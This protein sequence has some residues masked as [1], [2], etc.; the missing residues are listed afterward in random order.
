MLTATPL[1]NRL[2]DLYSLIDLLSVARGHE[3]PFGTEGIFARRFI[4]DDRSRARKLNQ[5]TK[6][7]FRSIVYGYMSRIRRGDANLHFP[8]RVVQLHRVQP[9]QEE[10][11]LIAMLAKPVRELRNRYSQIGILQSLTS[12]P[13][14]LRSRLKNMA[15]NGTF[16]A[17]VAGP[18][19][20]FIEKMPRSAKLQGLA[21]LVDSLIAERPDDWRMV[22]F[23]GSRETQTTIQ[24]Y[25]LQRRIPVGI[26]NGDSGPRN[27]E[28]IRKFW[29]TPHECRVI[30]STEAGSEGVNLQAANVLVN[31]DLPWNP[32]IVEQRIGRIQRL[33][34]EHAN[35]CI[36]NI[37]LDGTFE[38]FIVGRLM[39][40]L[41][42]A[43]HAIGDVESLLEAAGL[44]DDEESSAKSFEEKILDLVVAA[45]AGKNV[46]AATRKAAQSI[47][48]AKTVLESE[49]HMINETLGGM[50]G[51]EYVGP[52]APTLPP[53]ERSMEAIEFVE[54]ALRAS[55]AR[56]VMQAPGIYL[57]ERDGKSEQIQIA[58]DANGHFDGDGPLYAPGS[59]AFERLV[60][61]IVAAGIHVIEDEDRDPLERAQGIA[62]QW[63]ESLGA[64]FSKCS[65]DTVYRSTQGKALVRVRATV[66]HD[67]YERLVEVPCSAAEHT[68][69][70]KASGLD[71][72]PE[73][74]RIPAALG[75]NARAL[76]EDAA[77][78]AGI[79]EFCRFYSQR[80]AEELRAAGE[81]E[82]KRK[83]L[84][85]EFTPRL[86]F[87]L[88][89]L[90][91]KVHRT[92]TLSLGYTF[93]D[94]PEYTTTLTVVPRTGEVLQPPPLAA[95]EKSGRRAPQT[96]LAEC[97]ISGA[98]VLR[99]FLRQSELSGRLGLPEHTTLC[100]VTEK[101][102]LSDEVELSDVTGMLVSRDL[103]KS[104]AVSGKRAEPSEFARCAFTGSECLVSELLTSEV[105]G[106][107]YRSD[108]VTQS[109]VSG[110]RGHNQEFVSCYETR[111]PL[112]AVEVERCAATGKL[113]RPGILEPCAVTGE[114]VLPSEL[115]R[116]A[117]SGKRAHK[118]HFVTS[119]LSGARLLES[120]ATL[121]VAGAYCAPREAKVCAWSGQLT[122][123]DDLVVCDLTGLA[124][125]AEY[126]TG[127]RL[128]ILQGLL[129]QI[130]RPAERTDLW[131][132]VEAK[133][134]PALKVRHCQVETA[135]VS[136]DGERLAVSVRVPAYW[137]LTTEHAGC[138]DT[139]RCARRSRGAWEAQGRKMVRSVV[140][141]IV[142]CFLTTLAIVRHWR[143]ISGER[144]LLPSPKLRAGSLQPK[145]ECGCRT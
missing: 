105:S 2:W 25:L 119:S 121:S 76:T 17:E 96:C 37:I 126:A 118:R 35:V 95:C 137:G 129:D 58:Q 59:T 54:T 122:H 27:Q 106:K 88:A 73:V 98:R 77:S 44:D 71:P 92:V 11:H 139:G 87:D 141:S 110:K 144:K 29:K 20:Q 143:L 120:E 145:C 33:A 26:I 47:D 85:D 130:Q 16:P 45:L 15:R 63:A 28:T 94:S 66:A 60:G 30:V 31:Y 32:M 90:E 70:V 19:I 84:E 140:P 124:V 49:E 82:R 65:V 38:E 86:E 4:A 93:E 68:G 3:N 34:S 41:Q 91:G 97:A 5:R 80:K 13:D 21:T 69:A 48:Q 101:R 24:D 102:A 135:Q 43:S 42:L 61:G 99:H 81:D 55:G 64:A 133:V 142:L 6:E 57:C 74:I 50:D 23:T 39:E 136:P 128:Q 112:L 9:T 67:S 52:R 8:N 138:L 78:D 56:V 117:A 22:I 134:S 127:G 100:S 12:S 89:A 51:A 116:S 1:H 115:E 18:I 107:V 53:L 108:Q 104:S 75:I 114:R 83:K 111:Q 79:A 72:L 123:P 103:L 14:A 131:R 113:V 109:I 40:K 10:Q 36:F 7:E 46:E 132:A 62:R 125:R